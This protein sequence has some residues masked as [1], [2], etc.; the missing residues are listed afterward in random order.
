MASD[1]PRRLTLLAAGLLGAVGVSLSALA[2]HG[3]D[4]RLIA[5]AAAI[6]LA[7]APALLALHAGF[8][9]IRTAAIASLLIALGCALFAA[10]LLFR[11]AF[12]HGMFSMSAPLGGTMIIL[13]WL[14][15]AAGAFFR[16]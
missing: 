1:L 9:A 14:A 5:T 10:D 16:A 15:M 6:M 13:G 4:N 11:N 2:S 7:H 12:G 3:G 8:A